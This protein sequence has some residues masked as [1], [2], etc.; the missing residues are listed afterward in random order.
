MRS[1]IKR[2]VS[3]PRAYLRLFAT[4]VCLFSSLTLPYRYDPALSEWNLNENQYA[5]SATVTNLIPSDNM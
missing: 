3:G 4:L 2:H 5:L 1:D